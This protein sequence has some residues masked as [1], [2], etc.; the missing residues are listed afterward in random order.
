ML[1]GNILQ[2]SLWYYIMT[3]SIRNDESLRWHIEKQERNIQRHYDYIRTHDALLHIF[4]IEII[5]YLPKL[6]QISLQMGNNNSK[7][8]FKTRILL[9]H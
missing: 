2:I 1:T 4:V 6:G 8:L 9:K 7:H 5:T 3:I